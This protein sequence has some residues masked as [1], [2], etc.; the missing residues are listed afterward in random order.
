MSDESTES[1]LARIE[2]LYNQGLKHAAAQLSRLVLEKDPANVPAL[3]WL[4]RSS[5]QPEEAEKATRKASML[6]PDDPRVR[7]LVASRQPSFAGA[8]SAPAPYNPYAAPSA[9]FNPATEPKGGPQPWA[10]F[11]ASPNPAAPAY[12]P[13]PQPAYMPNPQGGSY[14]YLKNLSATVQPSV[15][16]AAPVTNVRVKN[17]VS[18]PGLIFGLLFLI[19]GLG[20]AGVWSYMI[21]DYNSDL[22]QTSNQLQGQVVKLSSEQLVVDVKNVG[23]RNFEISQEVSQALVPL[24]S[25]NKSSLVNNTVVLN[26]SPKGRLISVDVAAPNRGHAEYNAGLLGYGQAVDWVVTAVGALL[27]ILGLILLGRTL[28]K[29]R[30]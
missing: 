5:S 7:D 15:P 17:T 12:P 1:R 22:S 28:G 13:P 4:A 27:A 2:A 6:Q 10:N 30:T 26:I 21:I 29:R 25:D 3:V 11:S 24:I 9:G 20:L 8:A 16:P 23:Q 14:D 19:V 18:V